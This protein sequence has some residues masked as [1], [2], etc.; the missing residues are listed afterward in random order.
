MRDTRRARLILGLLL[1]VALILITV[2]RRAGNDHVLGPVRDFAGAVF[3]RVERVGAAVTRPITGFVG[4]LRDAPSAQRA[5]ADLRKENARLRD[6][7]SAQRLDKARAE[8]LDR[9]LGL[10]GLGRYRVVPAQ[11]VARRTVAGF[12]DT[13]EI[14][15]GT[16]DGL[17]PDMTVLSDAG[18]VGRIVQAGPDSST[19]ALLTDPALSAG[20]R[21]EGG[22]ELGVVSGLGEA[23]GGGNLV[24]FRLLDSTVPIGVGRRIVSFGSQRSKPYVPGVPI[25]VVER[26]DNTPGDV[27]RTAYARP[28]TDFSSLDVVGV[29]VAA[30][31]RDPRDAVLPPVPKPPKP[32]P[33]EPRRGDGSRGQA[34]ASLEAE[35]GLGD[36]GHDDRGHGAGDESRAATE[37]QARE[38]RPEAARERRGRHGTQAVDGEQ[39]AHERYAQEPERYAQ[40]PERYAQEQEQYAADEPRDAPRQ[41]DGAAADD[42]R[43]GRN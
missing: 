40:E 32:R 35:W 1:A 12:E 24:R 21:L 11:V 6:E 43:G 18:L 14:D 28:F 23:G 8:K 41:H 19:V 27:T 37:R 26:V 15:A 33:E 29:V 42:G 22:N 16:G 17:R 30:P 10:A 2:D 36:R 20:A 13:V 39:R 7:V 31:K 9:M 25:G 4:M 5:V 38:G 3:G 34:G